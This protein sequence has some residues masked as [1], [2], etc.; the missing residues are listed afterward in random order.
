MVP[1]NFLEDLSDPPETTQEDSSHN[2]SYVSGLSFFRS[3][4]LPSSIDTP[5]IVVLV[6]LRFDSKRPPAKAREKTAR[7]AVTVAML[8]LLSLSIPCF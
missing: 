1:S 4:F 8:S 3:S 2:D 5:T 6:L 7:A